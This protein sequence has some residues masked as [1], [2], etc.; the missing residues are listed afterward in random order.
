MGLLVL[1]TPILLTLWRKTQFA[2]DGKEFKD[3]FLLALR[4]QSK[5]ARESACAVLAAMTMIPKAR[6]NVLNLCGDHS[7][8]PILGTMALSAR[9]KFVKVSACK[10]LYGLN[11][12]GVIGH[13]KCSYGLTT[14][15]MTL[16]DDKR[17]KTNL[18][19]AAKIYEREKS[20]VTASIE[21]KEGKEEIEKDEKETA[22]NSA[23]KKLDTKTFE[24][25]ALKSTVASMKIQIGQLQM[26]VRELRAQVNAQRKAGDGER[27]VHHWH[28]K[29]RSQNSNFGRHRR[30]QRKD[31]SARIADAYTHLFLVC[32]FI[33][34]S[35]T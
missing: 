8:G 27:A 4:H 1:V 31:L 24:F 26:A 3:H 15:F 6:K 16:R 14:A 21:E 7:L 23:K 17:G 25:Q 11:A 10:A 32:S 33:T 30:A 34:L 2:L 18:A 28:Q 19:E 13:K 5:E 9:E 22:K 20:K 35:Q 29:D 12:I